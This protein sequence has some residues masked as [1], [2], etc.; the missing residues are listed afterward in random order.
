MADLY[1]AACQWCGKRGGTASGTPNGGLPYSTPSVPG[2][3]PCHPSGKENMP[4]SPK[5]ERR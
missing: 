2:K 5:W 4:H 1:Q 3:C